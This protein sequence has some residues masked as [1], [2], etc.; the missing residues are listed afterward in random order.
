M[1]FLLSKFEVLEKNYTSG[2][3]KGKVIFEALI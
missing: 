2:P 1:I 3:E